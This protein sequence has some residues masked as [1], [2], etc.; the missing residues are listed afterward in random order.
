MGQTY[1]GL[2][3]YG[4]R[5]TETPRSLLAACWGKAGRPLLRL[6][7][8]WSVSLRIWSSSCSSFTPHV[9]GCGLG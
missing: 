3:C 5:R 6:L 1:L 4:G 9:Q 7:A 2:G 8:L